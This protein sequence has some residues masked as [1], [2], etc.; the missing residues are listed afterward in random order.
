MTTGKSL[1]AKKVP[2]K[3]ERK[4]ANLKREKPA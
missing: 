4:H 3:S 1:P 2:V